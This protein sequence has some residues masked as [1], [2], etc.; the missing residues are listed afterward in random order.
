MHGV[1][2]FCLLLVDF[3]HS[4]AD[5]PEA[6]F[7]QHMNN[8]TGG[9]FG[10][11]VWFYDGKCALQCVHSCYVAPVQFKFAVRNEWCCISTLK[12]YLCA[13]RVL[14]VKTKLSLCQSGR[15]A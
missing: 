3:Q 8:V 15:A 10:H 4:H 6:F 13:L 14:A 11:C 2:A 9:A 12:I 1:K 5:D 7:L